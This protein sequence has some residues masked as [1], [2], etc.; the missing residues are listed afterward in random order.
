MALIK[1]MHNAK[2]SLTTGNGFALTPT[3][4]C[5]DVLIDDGGISLKKTITLSKEKGILLYL[6]N[7]YLEINEDYKT[8]IIWKLDANQKSKSFLILVY[9]PILYSAPT[10]PYIYWI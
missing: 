3:N 5:K 9:I 6:D 7:K 10:V 1:V 2:F 4:G 8:K